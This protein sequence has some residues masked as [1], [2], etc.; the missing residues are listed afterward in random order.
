MP[1]LMS[2]EMLLPYALMMLTMLKMLMPLRYFATLMLFFACYYAMIT[3]I[4]LR[5]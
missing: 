4:I 2:H 1:Q 3:A 5:C